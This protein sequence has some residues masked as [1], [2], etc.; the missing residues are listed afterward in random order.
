M[1]KPLQERDRPAA[2]FSSVVIPAVPMDRHAVITGQT[3]FTSRWKQFLPLTQQ[4]LFQIHMI[5]T[6]F[7]LVCKIYVRNFLPPLSLISS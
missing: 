5:S 4:K 3:L 2:F 6:V 1:I 7:L